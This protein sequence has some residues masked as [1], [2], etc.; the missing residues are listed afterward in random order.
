ME[1]SQPTPWSQPHK[2]KPTD[3]EAHLMVGTE[4]ITFRSLGAA[5][6]VLENNPIL[7]SHSPQ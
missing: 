6:W 5:G 1:P 4:G 3:S 2:A 7:A